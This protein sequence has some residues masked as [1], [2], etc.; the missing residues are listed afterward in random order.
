MSRV[1]TDLAWPLRTDR[2][3]LRLA[4]LADAEAVWHWFHLVEVHER[5]ATLSPRG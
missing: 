1:L 2:L 4:V 5:A 3:S